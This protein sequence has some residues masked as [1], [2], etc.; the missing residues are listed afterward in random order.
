VLVGEFHGPESGLTFFNNFRPKNSTSE[1][2]GPWRGIVV[3]RQP[4]DWPSGTPAR[5]IRD[6]EKWR[7]AVVAADAGD[8]SKLTKLLQSKCVLGPEARSLLADLIERH[9]LV[10]RPENPP[11]PAYLIIE[12]R[13]SRQLKLFQYFR[14]KGETK[15]D[16]IELALHAHKRQELDLKD[17]ALRYTNEQVDKM[18]KE[19]DRRKLRNLVEGR[20]ATTKRMQRR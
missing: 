16:A 14:G 15:E 18:I 6:H 11:M 7:E 9:R 3:R 8:T 4:I 1:L 20:R 13:L 17:D 5:A 19:A 10:R 2:L 12:A